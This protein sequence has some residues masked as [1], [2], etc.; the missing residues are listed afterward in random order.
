MNPKNSLLRQ[1]LLKINIHSI[2][3][4]VKSYLRFSKEISDRQTKVFIHNESNKLVVSQ[5]DTDKVMHHSLR[6]Y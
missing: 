1:N 4:L 2:F 3:S 6:Y 5:D